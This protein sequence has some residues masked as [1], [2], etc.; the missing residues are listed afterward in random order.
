MD[1]NPKPVFRNCEKSSL[2][3]LSR[4]RRRKRTTTTTTTTTIEIMEDN[5]RMTDSGGRLQQQ[6]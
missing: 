1:H 2:Y 6:P 4:R 5:I 3:R